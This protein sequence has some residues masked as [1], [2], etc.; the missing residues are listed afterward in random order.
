MVLDA[1]PFSYQLDDINST[2]AL[3]AR[4]QSEQARLGFQKHK[5][6][7]NKQTQ[8]MINYAPSQ[9][10]NRPRHAP[11]GFQ[12]S[13]EKMNPLVGSSTSPSP[14]SGSS[15][16]F[17]FMSLADQQLAQLGPIGQPLAHSST[18]SSTTSGKDHIPAPMSAGSTGST[19]SS[20]SANSPWNASLLDLNS[21]TSIPFSST[22]SQVW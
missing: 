21:K 6:Q 11:Q 12:S 2:I 9:G 14:V 4:Y 18:V 19:I 17:S 8:Q 5:I 7:R 1:V 3:T 13:F 20:G 10:F 16:D 15:S 22:W